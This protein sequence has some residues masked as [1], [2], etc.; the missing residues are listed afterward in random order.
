MATKTA[1]K[2]DVMEVRDGR[3]IIDVALDPNPPFSKSG[4]TRIHF[5]TGGFV[6]VGEYKLG[7]NLI[8]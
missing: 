1:V 3:L 6:Q 8:K 4:K 2:Q 7:V 5:G